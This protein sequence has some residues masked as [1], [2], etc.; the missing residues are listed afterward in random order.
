MNIFQRERRRSTVPKKKTD[1][2]SDSDHQQKSKKDHGFQFETEARAVHRRHQQQPPTQPV[3]SAR[4]TVTTT[5][6]TAPPPS[7][8]A[9]SSA[10]ATRDLASTSSTQY[11][12]KP[13]PEPVKTEPK[14]LTLSE[15]LASIG[16]ITSTIDPSQDEKPMNNESVETKK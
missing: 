11:Q 5:T 4:K 3:K 15:R 8:R 9:K 16:R 7:R 6:P 12:S 1:D 10:A 13:T 2:N 14:E